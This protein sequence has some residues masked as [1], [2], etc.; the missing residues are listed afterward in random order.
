MVWLC[1]YGYN[2]YLF[3]L[4]YIFGRDYFINEKSWG[5]GVII[6]FYI[7]SVCISMIFDFMI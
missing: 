7:Y 5:E 3:V 4:L 6:M 2:I 1:C